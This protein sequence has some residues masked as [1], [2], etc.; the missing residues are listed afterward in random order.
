MHWYEKSFFF[1]EMIFRREFQGVNLDEDIRIWIVHTH[2]IH[3]NHHHYHS[4]ALLTSALIYC[5]DY[6]KKVRQKKR[7][8]IY[9]VYLFE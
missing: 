7:R 9:S 3:V 5:D 1:E 4:Q 6:E 2:E 8:K